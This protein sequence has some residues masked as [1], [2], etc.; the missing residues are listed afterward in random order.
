MPKDILSATAATV[1]MELYCVARPSS[2]TAV[3]RPH[4]S[5]KSG[6]WVAL[7]GESV[8]EGIAGFGATVEAALAAFDKQYLKSTRPVNQKTTVR[9]TS[10]NRTH[11]ASARRVKARFLRG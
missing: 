9:V 5:I 7:L 3:R 10:R 11:D 8:Q 1:H 4:L 6:V 2:P